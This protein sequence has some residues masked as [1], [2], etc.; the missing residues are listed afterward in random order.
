MAYEVEVSDEFRGWY[1][2]LSEAEQLSI[3][4]VIELLEGNCAGFP[5]SSRPKVALRLFLRF[6][7]VPFLSTAK[8][9]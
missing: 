7:T 2:P 6:F 3:G 4:R 9:P 5:Y 8:R 1:E